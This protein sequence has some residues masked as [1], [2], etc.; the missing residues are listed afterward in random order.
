MIS[1]P[2]DRASERVTAEAVALLAAARK[3]KGLSYQALGEAAG[4]HRT[5]IS[6]IERGK[7]VANANSVPQARPRHRRRSRRFDQEGSKK[8]TIVWRL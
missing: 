1:V 8:C 6:L 7:A 2:R 4:I 5:T 3:T